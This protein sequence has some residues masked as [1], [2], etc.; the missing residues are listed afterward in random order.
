MPKKWTLVVED[1]NGRTVRKFEGDGMP[2]ADIKWD[3][4]DSSGKIVKMGMYSYYLDWYDVNNDLH[5]SDKRFLS[6]QK[7]HRHIKVE[8][9]NKPKSKGVNADEINIILKE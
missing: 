3:W 8:I 5:T 1:A 7:L 6:V 4:T 2:P 9:T